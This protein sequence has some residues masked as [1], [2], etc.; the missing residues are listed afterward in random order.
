M[1]DQSPNETNPG[2]FR[3]IP[4]VW[5]N[6]GKAVFGIQAIKDPATM[7]LKMTSVQLAAKASGALKV[8]LAKV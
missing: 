6:T 8:R 4:I 7:A 5:N 2:L 1:P 3:T